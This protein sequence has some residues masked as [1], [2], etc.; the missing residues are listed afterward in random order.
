MS[1]LESPIG[2]KKGSIGPVSI[3]SESGPS[4]K[5]SVGPPTLT[6][7]KGPFLGPI[8]EVFGKR[9]SKEDRLQRIKATGGTPAC[10]DAVLRSLRWLK[11][12]QQPD[13]SW[14]GGPSAAMTGLALL[15]Y[16]G[17]CETYT[18]EEFGESCLKGIIY[19]VNLGMKNDGKIAS[20]YTTQSWCY[21]HAIAT[22]A[23]AEASTFCNNPK[24]PIP[25]LKEVTEKAGQYIIDHQADNGGWAYAYV[26][27]KGHTDT[28]VVGWQIQA[29][30]AC[31]HTDIRYK[32]MPSCIK[33]GLEYLD[34]TQNG[35]GAFGYTGPPPA[36]GKYASL[37]GVGVLCHQMWGEGKK[38]EVT[39]GL[40]YIKEN[41]KFDW[42]TAD[43]NLYAAYYESQ[44]M[45]Q[46]G[47]KDWLFYNDLIRDQLLNNQNPDGSWNATT[48]KLHGDSTT[49]R[50]AL[51]T[52]MLEVYYRFTSSSDR[53]ASGSRIDIH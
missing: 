10:E 29:L 45:M 11:S 18:S 14:G 40:K 15:A 50:T 39:K 41:V 43:S 4:D 22:Y 16:F 26:T 30:K 42:N 8:P 48:G 53:G 27:T 34:S 24:L 47:G 21:E 9:C 33:K 1:D 3:S 38:R 23:L 44:A 37:T 7:A 6:P 13:G 12:H 52:L 17:H 36:D 25:Y 28:S 46:S 51:C 35:S 49:Y 5:N 32:G 20:N 19:L 2:D 31:S